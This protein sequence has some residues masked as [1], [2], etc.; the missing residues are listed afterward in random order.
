MV[1]FAY[2]GWLSW[3]D[4]MWFWIG[5]PPKPLGCEKVHEL[6]ERA[7]PGKI[8]VSGTRGHKCCRLVRLV[9]LMYHPS[10]GWKRQVK[11]QYLPEDTDQLVADLAELSLTHTIV[12]VDTL[13]GVAIAVMESP[14]HETNIDGEVIEKIIG[15]RWRR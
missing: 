5:N 15:R 3:N 13:P 2:E 10:F 8:K 9:N 11:L 1:G 12:G 4:P 14:N 7:V 6:L